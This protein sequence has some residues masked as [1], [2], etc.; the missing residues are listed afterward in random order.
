MIP[1]K[2]HP[3]AQIEMLKAAEYYE[4]QQ[5]DLGKRFLLTVQEKVKHIRLNPFIYSSFES[6]LRK[7]RL[8]TFPYGIVFR[9]TDKHIEIIAVVNLRREPGYWKNRLNFEQD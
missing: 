8:D 1:A 4:L 2:F 9:S 7:C 3:K 6:N 5:F